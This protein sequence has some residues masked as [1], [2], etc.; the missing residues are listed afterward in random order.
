MRV[1]D[2]RVL[3]EDKGL[4]CL[5]GRSLPSP[6]ASLDLLNGFDDPTVWENQPKEELSWVPPETTPRGFGSTP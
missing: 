3:D 5:L 2:I 6:D 1:E 4:L